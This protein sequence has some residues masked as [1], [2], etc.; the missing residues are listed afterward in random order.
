MREREKHLIVHNLVS[1]PNLGLVNLSCQIVTVAVLLASS[2]SSPPPI[3][4]ALGHAALLVVHWD[5]IDTL[6]LY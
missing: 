3:L 4:P 2:V 5:C 6:C 1:G